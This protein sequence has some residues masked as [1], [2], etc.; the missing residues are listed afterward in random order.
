MNKRIYRVDNIKVLLILLVILGQFLECFKGYEK[1]YMIIYSFHMP[2]FI[3]VFGLFAK[4]RKKR[5]VSLMIT[6]LI[7]QGLY[8][9]YY[10]YLYKPEVKFTFNY[11][12]PYWLLWFLFCVIFYLLLIPMLEDN[13]GIT[14]IIVTLVTIT[15]SLFAGFDTHIG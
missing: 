12:T 15:L 11:T 14:K 9:K 6:Y 3:F 8:R 4:F 7:F 10:W 2:F 13:K 5:I 1:I